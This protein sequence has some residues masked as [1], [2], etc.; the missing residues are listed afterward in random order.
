MVAFQVKLTTIGFEVP[1]LERV[2]LRLC[3]YLNLGLHC[4]HEYF[5]EFHEEVFGRGRKERWYR[6]LKRGKNLVIAGIR[7]CG[8]ILGTGKLILF[9]SEIG[10]KINAKTCQTQDPGAFVKEV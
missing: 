5:H 10:Q 4:L 1:S 9:S 2:L 6:S 8:S 3:Q 7:F